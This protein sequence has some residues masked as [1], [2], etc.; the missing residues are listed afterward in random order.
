MT[1]KTLTNIYKN[2]AKKNYQSVF[3]G[4][5]PFHLKMS[6]HLGTLK[7]K[8]QTLYVTGLN[9]DTKL[10]WKTL[11]I[12]FRLILV[13]LL[14][15][16]VFR[17]AANQILSIKWLLAITKTMAGKRRSLVRKMSRLTFTH[18]S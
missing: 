11:T 6:R 1:V 3:Q 9:L 2:M 5:G 14:L 4:L 12:S 15:S 18:T 16:L 7:T 13:S 10:A 17:V 8:S